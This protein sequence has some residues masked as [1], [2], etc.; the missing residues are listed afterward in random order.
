MHTEREELSGSKNTKTG[1][2]R[3][4]CQKFKHQDGGSIYGA[5]QIQT[6]GNLS[7][8]WKQQQEMAVQ[9]FNQS[10]EQKKQFDEMK[11]MQESQAL[12]QSIGNTVGQFFGRGMQAV[13]QNIREKKIRKIKL[14]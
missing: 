10:M 12:G 11:R 3:I 6:N 5:S 14:V 8:Q 7:Q 2:L 9:N 4:E 13:A 1:S